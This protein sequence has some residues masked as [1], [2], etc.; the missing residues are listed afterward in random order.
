[1]RRST[2]V[3]SLAMCVAPALAAGPTSA[4]TLRDDVLHATEA[5]LHGSGLSIE[6]SRA[7]VLASRELRADESFVLVPRWSARDSAPAMP[8]TFDLV[9][10]GAPGAASGGAARVTLVTSLRREVLVAR[11]RIERGDAVSCDDLAVRPLDLRAVP[12]RAL[13]P[14]CAMADGDVALRT[15][16]PGDALRA[17]DIG[18]PPDVSARN[19]VNV[20]VVEGAIRLE[21]SGVALA[22]A[23]I[24]E[25][26]PVRLDGSRQQVQGR[27]VA[28]NVVVVEGTR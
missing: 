28:A 24:G 7:Q 26:V 4:T 11:Q 18:D 23:R 14:P 15:L 25:R 2:A 9:P 8:L 20:R 22:D 19:P 1:M 27:V 21:Q 12:V 17:D 3:L 6:V 10:A 13:A 16:L 5:L